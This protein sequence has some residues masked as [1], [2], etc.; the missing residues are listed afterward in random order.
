MITQGARVGRGS[1]LGEASLLNPGIPVIDAQTG[2]E[3]GRGVVPPGSLCI[4]ASRRRQFPGGEFGLPCL[5][6][7][8]GIEPGDRQHLN[9]ILRESG[10]TVG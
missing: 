7:L 8:R 2:D 4:Q 5:L 6:V 1:I 10:V 9:D 3:L